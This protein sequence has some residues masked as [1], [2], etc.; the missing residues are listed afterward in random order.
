MQVLNTASC[1]YPTGM[2]PIIAV[3]REYVMWKT[4]ISG[5]A[6]GWAPRLARTKPK[7]TTPDGTFCRVQ[8]GV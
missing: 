7:Y 4:S 6:A 5:Q 2:M 3:Y 1:N 8:S